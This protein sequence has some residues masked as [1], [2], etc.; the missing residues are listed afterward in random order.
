MGLTKHILRSRVAAAA[1]TMTRAF[2]DDPVMEWIFRGSANRDE[3]VSRFMAISCKRSISIGHAYEPFGGGGAAFWAPPGCSMYT[4]DLGM[5]IYQL[6]FGAVGE[7]RTRTVLGGLGEATNFH[8]E[9]PHFYLATIGIEPNF[10]GRG[11][12][13]TLMQRV[14]NVCDDENIVAYLES[15]NPRNVSLYERAGFETITDVPLPGGPVMRPMIR[16]PRSS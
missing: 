13:T 4:E 1:T 16:Q 7:E 2:A 14:L 3:L 6:L 5:E 15:S 10:Q 11:L 12:G 8:P 9:E